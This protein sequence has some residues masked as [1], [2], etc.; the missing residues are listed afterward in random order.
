MPPPGLPSASRT[1]PPVVAPVVHDS[2]CYE[3]L[4]GSHVTD[5]HPDASYLVARDATTRAVLWVVEVYRIVPIEELERDVQE[6]CF[7]SLRLSEDGARLL[8]E[9]EC[10]RHYAVDIA[11]RTARRLEAA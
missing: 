11:A 9:D 4:R 8:V 1:A 7:R 5:L 6:V 10:R 2:V 3:Q